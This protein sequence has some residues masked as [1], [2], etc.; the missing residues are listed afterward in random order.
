MKIVTHKTKE[1]WL[2]WRNLAIGSSDAAAVM[3]EC[4]FTTIEELWAKKIGL[5]QPELPTFPMRRGL[6][7]EPLAREEYK[8]IKGF[9]MPKAFIE[10]E[11][12]KYAF[13]SLDGMNR[14]ERGALEVKAPGKEDHGLALSGKI[15]EHYKWQLVHILMA[16]DGELD[17]VDYYSHH[18]VTKADPIRFYRDLKMEAELAAAEKNFWEKNVL[19]CIEPS[20]KIIPLRS[21][22]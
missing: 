14:K 17:W 13:A 9:P 10:S 18:P 22:K 11:T 5:L 16:A 8:A 7:L 19:Q 6:L 15:P 1:D 3:Q 2:W 20:K 21:V 4:P 12:H